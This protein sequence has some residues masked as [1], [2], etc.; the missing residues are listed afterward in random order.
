M[1]KSFKKLYLYIYFKNKKFVPKIFIKFVKHFFSLRKFKMGFFNNFLFIKLRNFPDLLKVVIFLKKLGMVGEE[2]SIFFIKLKRYFMTY[3]F[4]LK[5]FYKLNVN[6]WTVL[7]IGFYFGNLYRLLLLD[8]ILNY[9]Y[10]T[11]NFFKR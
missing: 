4:F 7:V 9:G 2:S 8:T 11:P 1:S 3:D 6:I 5:N 10:F